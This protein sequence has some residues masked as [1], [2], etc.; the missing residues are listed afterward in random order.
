MGGKTS[1]TWGP[2]GRPPSMAEI[3][4]SWA[5]SPVRFVREAFDGV[6]LSTQ[7]QQAFEAL[8]LLVWSKIKRAEGIPMTEL[9]AEYAPKVGLSVMSGH[10][11]G[12]DAFC[13]LT[14]LW[15]LYCF[16]F[17]KI[18]C[19]AP[20]GHQLK[21]V[22]WSE[23]NKW[24]R[25]SKIKDAITW[26]AEKIFL[27]EQLGREWFAVPRTANPKASAEEQAETL[28]G[29]NA[30]YKLMIADEASGIP[31]PVFLPLEG[32]L[33]GKCNVAILI[34]NPTRAKGYAIDSQTKDRARWAALRW[35]AEESELTNKDA[36]KA[37]EQK[38]GRDSN[39][40]R[41]R[42]L[43]LPPKT[44]KDTLI[45]WEWVEECIE[46]DDLVALDTD[47]VVIGLDVGAGG[48]TSILLRRQGPLVFPV[49]GIE[50]PESEKLTGWALRRLAMY[51]PELT[52][53]DTI[54]VGWGIEGNLR[55]RSNRSIIGV[56]V[57][58]AAPDD[59]RF[60]RLRDE[61]WWRVRTAFEQRAISIPRDDELIG[62]LTSIK[63]TDETTD[64]RI[65][66]ESKKDM[67]RRGL[68]SPNKADALCLTFYYEA[69]LLRALTARRRMPQ[70]AYAGSWK[71][72]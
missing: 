46:R 43:G 16:P 18:L 53:V 31:D 14:I 42:V 38:Y 39:F 29:V 21:D 62:E 45:P 12:K 37:F 52:M 6:E 32:G 40:Y 54:G 34:F 58:E 44:E 69:S 10:L 57:A 47:P 11:A 36:I 66:V 59:E 56:N 24:L 55:A 33:T 72:A 28:A 1:T 2:G 22:L 30:E 8:R 20:T 4:R 65:K 7:Q 67:K 68:S 63:W 50:T 60:S 35:N 23:V 71:T 25:K 15:F 51:E 70:R 5:E 9:E 64:G 17:P 61:L 48:D 3:V 19:T 26:Q 41:I 27:T 13:A 49:E